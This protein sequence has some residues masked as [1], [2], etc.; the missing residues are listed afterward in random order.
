MIALLWTLVENGLDKRLAGIL[1]GVKWVRD[2][3]R[4]QRR[5]ADNDEFPRLPDDVQMPAQRGEAAEHAG[6]SYD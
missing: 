6:E 5:S 1:D 3:E 4:A 2:D